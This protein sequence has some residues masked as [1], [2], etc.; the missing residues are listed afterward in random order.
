MT[1][2]K[3]KARAA[4]GV[5]VALSETIRE[6][7]QVPSGT[8]YARVMGYLTLEQYQSIIETLK[9]TGLVVEDQS[10][11]LRWVGPQIEKGVA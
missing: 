4:V 2:T 11:L 9:R 3:E 7:G 6:L 8:L 10:Y 1:I 5:L